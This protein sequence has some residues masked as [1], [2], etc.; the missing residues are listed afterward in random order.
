MHFLLLKGLAF[1]SVKLN[2]S[3]R[4]ELL[5]NWEDPQVEIYR[6]VKHDHKRLVSV[7]KQLKIG[8]FSQ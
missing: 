6:N 7:E 3:A 1:V 8:N 4:P 2:W 5:R